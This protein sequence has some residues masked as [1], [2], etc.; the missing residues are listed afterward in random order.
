MT[1]KLI[2]IDSL[3][4]DIDLEPTFL[5]LGSFD[6]VHR[7]HQ[8][9]LGEMIEAAHKAGVRSAVLTF[10]PHPKRVLQG[11][12]DRYYINTLEDRETLLAG[13]G[14]DLVITHPFNEDIRKIR[15]ADF[16]NQLRETFD[17]R[18]IWGGNFALGYKREGDISFLRRLGS[19][20]G[21]SVHIVESMVQW[22]ERLVSSSRVRNS[23]SEGN[24]SDVNGCLG[25]PY[26]LSGTVVR[27]DQRG[28]TISFPTANLAVWEELI[29]PANGVYA[30]YA[31]IGNQRF[32]AA[33]NVGVRPTINGG[34]RVVE[35]H[36]LDFNGD[37][38]GQTVRL[39]FS[40]Y[41]RPEKK[42][43]G[44][45]ALKEQIRTDVVEVRRQL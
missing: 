42:F 31:W 39:E 8:T 36:L 5:T 27:G 18:Q 34:D 13:L 33:T 14:V 25:R 15:A 26:S 40:R 10:F 41:L 37:I 45:E 32:L 17:M 3:A 6:G 44:L 29:L 23:L 19:E 38:Y 35:A 28:R 30:T 24:I 2:R 9:V 7:G 21:F 16:I 4:N 12:R 20:N 22:N 11:L 1:Q 43:S